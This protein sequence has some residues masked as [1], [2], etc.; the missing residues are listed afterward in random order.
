MNFASAPVHKSMPSHAPPIVFVVNDDVSVRA[1]LQSLVVSAGWQAEVFACA[2]EFL[3]YPRVFAPGCLLLDVNL[4]DVNGLDLQKRVS[5]DRGDLPIIFITGHGNVPI[6][7]QAMKAGAIEFLTKPFRSDVLLSAVH[8]AIERSKALLCHEAQLRALRERHA[9]LSRR[10]REVMALVVCGLLNKQVSGELGISEI[11][12][13][14]H[15]G[16]M[17]RKMRTRSLPELVTIAARL[18][19]VTAGKD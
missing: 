9:S 14:Q 18:G 2:R 5:A 1:S 4:R 13:K 15:R 12:V 17:M 6:A 7:V 8:D 10:E 16:R 19:F 11:T 3:A